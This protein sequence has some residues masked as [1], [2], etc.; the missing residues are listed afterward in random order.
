MLSLNHDVNTGCSG[1]SSHK[2]TYQQ[3]N[4]LNYSTAIETNT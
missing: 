3:N 1:S 2:L 4:I